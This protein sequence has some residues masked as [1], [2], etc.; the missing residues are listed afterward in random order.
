LVEE[1]AQLEQNL[2]KQGANK[3]EINKQIDA[4]DEKISTGDEVLLQ[5]LEELDLL[6]LVKDGLLLN[7]KELEG[8]LETLGYSTE[9]AAELARILSEETID[10]LNSKEDEAKEAGKKKGDKHA[11]GVDSTKGDN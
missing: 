7:S 3:D 1:R 2:E 8:Y 11:E 10:G 5:M 9:E 6:D 4:L